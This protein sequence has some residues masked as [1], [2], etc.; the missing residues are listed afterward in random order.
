MAQRFHFAI[1]NFSENGIFGHNLRFSNSAICLC[2]S[3][4]VVNIENLVSKM[5]LGKYLAQGQIKK[6]PPNPKTECA[7]LEIRDVNDDLS[8]MIFEV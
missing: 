5:V 2:P 7:P 6:K 8:T 3:F 1:F 4:L